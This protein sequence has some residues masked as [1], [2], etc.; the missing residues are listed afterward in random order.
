MFHPAFL[1]RLKWCEVKS[2]LNDLPPNIYH[3]YLMALVLTLPHLE[4]LEVIAAFTHVYTFIS[5][6]YKDR[7]QNRNVFY[8]LTHSYLA[9]N[10]SYICIYI[11]VL[12]EVIVYD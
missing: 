7:V 5:I 11:S 6:C 1:Q 9:D 12:S 4:S 8:L 10:M 3:D 2:E